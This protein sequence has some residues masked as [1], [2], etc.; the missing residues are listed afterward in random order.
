M[1]TLE[2]LRN[3]ARTLPLDERE[4]LLAVLD[5]DLHGEQTFARGDNDPQIDAAW[6]NEISRRVADV[7]TGSVELLNHAEF[8]SGFDDARAEMHGQPAA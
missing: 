8:M 1:T 2:R 4:A 7:E 3:E 5:Y 6:E